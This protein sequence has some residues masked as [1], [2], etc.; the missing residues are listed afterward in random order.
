MKH[1]HRFLT[2]RVCGLRTHGQLVVIGK[3]LHWGNR[4]GRDSG[5]PWN[6]FLKTSSVLGPS[7]VSVTSFHVL[8][9]ALTCVLVQ[10]FVEKETPW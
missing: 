3:C 8:A 9:S 10:F 6:A 5:I 7:D 1:I 4:Q 2:L